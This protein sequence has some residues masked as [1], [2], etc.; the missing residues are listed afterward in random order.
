MKA[1]VAAACPIPRPL[2]AGRCQPHTLR[3][4]PPLP[5]ADATHAADAADATHIADGRRPLSLAVTVSGGNLS[6]HPSID[7]FAD[8]RFSRST[9]VVIEVRHSTPRGAHGR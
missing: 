7:Q 1:A 8:P 6:R 4:P 5:A 2:S 9:T 3:R